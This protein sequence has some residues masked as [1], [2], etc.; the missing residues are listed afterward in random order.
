VNRVKT[1][2]ASLAA[3]LSACI[4][5]ATV[6]PDAIAMPS[7]H[8]AQHVLAR[9]KLIDYKTR[10]CLDSNYHGTV[11]TNPCWRNDNYQTWDETRAGELMDNQT[12]RCLRGGIDRLHVR[13]TRCGTT[14]GWE[15]GNVPNNAPVGTGTLTDGAYDVPGRLLALDSNYTGHAYEGPTNNGPYQLWHATGTLAAYVNIGA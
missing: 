7:A 15:F 3:L 1:W 9:G 4:G 11:Y 10:R 14:A 5:I 8:A 6:A 12:G 2:M 13:T